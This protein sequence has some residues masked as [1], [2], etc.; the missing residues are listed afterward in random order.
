MNRLRTIG[1]LVWC[2]SL[3]GIAAA[4]APGAANS[5]AAANLFPPA[6]QSWT[7][8]TAIS[9]NRSA[10]PAVVRITAQG[11]GSVSY[12]SGCLVAVNATHGLVITNWHVIN[13]ATGPV[14]V[15]FPDGFESAATIQKVDRDWDL[16]AL[17]IW[18][19]NVAPVT[20]SRERRGPAT[21]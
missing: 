14:T 5:S 1:T 18:K 11:K 8:P 3:A 9:T 17:T 12:G 4:Q 19:P 15:D 16:A 20:M 10:H 13:E 21:C 7:A 6:G 2:C